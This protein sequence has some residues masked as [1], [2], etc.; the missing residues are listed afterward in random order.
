MTKRI[1][2]PLLLIMLVLSGMSMAQDN[3]TL[4]GFFQN[5][6]LIGAAPGNT[7]MNDSL[8]VALLQTHFNILTPENQMKW[9]PIHPQPDKWNFKPMDDL[10]AF[11]ESNNMKVIGHTLVWHSQSPN[12]VFEDE[13]KQPLSREQLLQR[14]QEHINTVMGRYKGKI[15]GYDVVNEAVIDGD[16]VEGVLRDSK[17]RRII[18]DDF[19]VQAFTFAKQADPDAQLY[20]NDY[21]MCNPAKRARTVELIKS[22]QKS[23][24]KI[25]AVGMQGHWNIYSPPLEEI[26]KSIIAFSELGVKVMITELDMSLFN[27]NDTGDIY[28]DSVPDSII[29]LQT[30]R[31]VEIFKLLRKHADVI[32]RVTFWGTTDRFSWLNYWPKRRTNYPLLFD[33]SAQPKPV[34]YRII[35]END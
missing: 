20:Y 27:S 18:G 30:D 11:A 33:R 34:M 15:Y 32:D 31:Y 2:F 24:V 21:D 9:G 25:D 6:F 22:L 16:S 35:N 10:V 7:F 26:E 17:W 8:V 29:Q 28:K 23:G 13:N 1:M 5:D 14:M 4:K 12:W 19:L 3:A